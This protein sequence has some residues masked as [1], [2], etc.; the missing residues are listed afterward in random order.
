MV[1]QFIAYSSALSA[2]SE[3]TDTAC[4]LIC[5]CTARFKKYTRILPRMVRYILIQAVSKESQYCLK[6]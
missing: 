2:D 6:L 3:G 5:V 1:E 4:E